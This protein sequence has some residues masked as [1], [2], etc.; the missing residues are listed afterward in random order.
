M[1]LNFSGKYYLPFA[2]SNVEH[3]EYCNGRGYVGWYAGY[4]IEALPQFRH[5]Y[6]MTYNCPV[7]GWVGSEEAAKDEVYFEVL[8]QIASEHNMWV[9]YDGTDVF[10]QWEAD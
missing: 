5:T 6:T 7:C 8:E 1:E 2:C 10:L 4:N 9:Y 3:C